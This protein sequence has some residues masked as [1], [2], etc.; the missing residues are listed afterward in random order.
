LRKLDYLASFM[1]GVGIGVAAS[2]MMSPKG[3][4]NT[5]NR[6]RSTDRPLGDSRKDDPENP[7]VAPT[8][9]LRERKITGSPKQSAERKTIGRSKDKPKQHKTEVAAAGAK[10]TVN[11]IIHKSK[12]VAHSAGIK[13]ERKRL[14]NA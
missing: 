2:I 11:R 1:A 6:S 13:M 10:K 8:S 7:G 5:L 12:D 14:R 4:G 9:V 3:G